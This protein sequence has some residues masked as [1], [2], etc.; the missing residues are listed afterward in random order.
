[1]VTPAQLKAYLRL[2]PSDAE[3]LE[4]FLLAAKAK[5]SSAGIPEF[6]YNAL[7]DQ[8]LLQF[9][10]LLYESRSLGTEADPA[11]VQSLI[12]S[13]VLPLRYMEDGEEPEPE[14]EPDP[15]PDPDPEVTDPTEEQQGVPG[16]G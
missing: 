9:A 7:Y 12:N 2:P 1:M 6:Q 5:A 10:G 8:F 4:G 16:D 14:P 3:D 11:K 15:D 13:F